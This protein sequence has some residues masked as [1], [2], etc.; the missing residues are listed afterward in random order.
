[1]QFT[2]FWV[3]AGFWNISIAT[4]FWD[5]LTK[6]KKSI[7]KDTWLRAIVFLFGV[8]YALVGYDRLLFSPV[9]VIGAVLKFGVY[10]AQLINIQ[11]GTDKWNS[12]LSFVTYG[13]LLWSLG[14][15]YMYIYT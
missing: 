7:N 4:I 8:L 15:M 12:S 14:F 11:G 2:Y 13:D 9:I 6:L 1:M 10:V 3:A 5:S